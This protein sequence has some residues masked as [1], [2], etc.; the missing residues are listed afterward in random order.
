MYIILIKYGAFLIMYEMGTL[1][2]I[3]NLLTEVLNNVAVDLILYKGS[4]GKKP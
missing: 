3:C 1:S 2:I 4:E